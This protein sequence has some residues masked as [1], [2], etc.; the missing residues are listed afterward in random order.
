MPSLG[1]VLVNIVAGS[2][3]M[4]YFLYGRRAHRAAFLL[5]GLGLC[6]LPFLV[7]SVLM[8]VVASAVLAAAPF[9]FR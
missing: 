4:G 2:L 3:G 9:L 8:Q 1:T 7:E 6:A 5:A